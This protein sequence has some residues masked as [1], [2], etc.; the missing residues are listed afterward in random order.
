LVRRGQFHQNTLGS[1]VTMWSWDT[2]D[3]LR[4]WTQHFLG[5]GADSFTAQRRA[6]AM[7]YRDMQDQAQVL[8]Y[9]DVYVVLVLLFTGL[10]FLVP[11]M[12]RVRAEQTGPQGSD[13][14][15]RV[16]PLP[17]PISE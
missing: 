3:R 8:A 4:L 11:W 12:H 7:L 5:L 13:P 10:L 16:E 17:E 2:A 15:G 6:V 14:K 1:H 9:A